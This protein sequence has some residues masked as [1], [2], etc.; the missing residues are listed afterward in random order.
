MIAEEHSITSHCDGFFD[1]RTPV[2]YACDFDMVRLQ[3]FYQY[4]DV[5]GNTGLV[6]CLDFQLPVLERYFGNTVTIR[7]IASKATADLFGIPYGGKGG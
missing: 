3:G 4:L 7:V 1:G 2:L 5:S 6:F